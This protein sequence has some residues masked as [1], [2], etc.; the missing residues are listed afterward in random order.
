[1]TTLGEDRVRGVYNAHPP[2]EEIKEIKQRTA[3]LIDYADALSRNN[4]DSEV[5]RLCALAMTSYEEG[6]MWLVK[7][8]TRG[9]TYLPDVILPP[10]VT[11]TPEP[12]KAQIEA[13]EI[14]GRNISSK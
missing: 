8:L 5:K 3:E 13:T 1:M 6:A 12:S 10:T 14:I 11:V 7:A 4:A 9:G 2:G